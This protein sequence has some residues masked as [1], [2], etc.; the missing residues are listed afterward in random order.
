MATI[1]SIM[2]TRAMRAVARQST[3]LFVCVCVCRSV[4]EDDGDD[5]GGD[6]G[7]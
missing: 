6:G 1:A 2:P 3:W 7:G 4:G 5:G